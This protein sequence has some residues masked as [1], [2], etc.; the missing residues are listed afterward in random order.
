[1]SL[2]LLGNIKDAAVTM[3]VVMLEVMRTHARLGTAREV[4]P[5]PPLLELRSA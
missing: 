5:A 4:T 3:N 1:M 2:I